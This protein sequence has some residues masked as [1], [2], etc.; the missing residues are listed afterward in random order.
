VH[1]I[2]KTVQPSET[3]KDPNGLLPRCQVS[4]CYSLAG[5][6]RKNNIQR[7][8]CSIE[9]ILGQL[10]LHRETNQPTKQPNNNNSKNHNTLSCQSFL[11]IHCYLTH[12]FLIHLVFHLHHNNFPMSLNSLPPPWHSPGPECCLS[13]PCPVG[14]LAAFL[15][16]ATRG[17]PLDVTESSWSI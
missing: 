9:R 13:C 5:S 10:V 14:H 6:P 8:G 7:P 1:A 12:T 2:Q 11:Q 3:R 4:T 17:L 16:S 15:A